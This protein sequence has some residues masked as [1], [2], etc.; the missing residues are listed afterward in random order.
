MLTNQ[1]PPASVTKALRGDNTLTYS[2]YLSGSGGTNTVARAFSPRLPT[3][4]WLISKPAAGSLHFL[5]G[6]IL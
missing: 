2:A 4:F 1:V 5:Y 3:L 6:E